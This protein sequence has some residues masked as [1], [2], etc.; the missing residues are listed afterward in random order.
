MKSQSNLSGTIKDELIS[1]ITK[2][3]QFSKVPK[4]YV[5]VAALHPDNYTFLDSRQEKEFN[6]SHIKNS[7]YVGDKDF[8]ID[9]LSQIPQNAN[10]V[11]YCSVGIRSDKI[12]KEIID[13]GYSNV[14]N[15]VGGIFE[16]INKGNPVFDYTG[17]PTQNIHGYS[18]I[19]GTFVNSS[20]KV[21]N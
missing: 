13:A 7:I 6:V 2:S 9:K 12:A 11:V 3:L 4:I 19:W 14:H 16:W 21:Y 5:E 15:M 1:I 17:K 10:I 8:S 18:K 20:H